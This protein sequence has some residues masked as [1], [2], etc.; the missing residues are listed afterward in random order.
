MS[1]PPG[2]NTMHLKA[3]LNLISFDGC[4]WFWFSHPGHMILNTVDC[5]RPNYGRL[6]HNVDLMMSDFAG[7]AS[8]FPMTFSGGKYT[9]E[10][11]R[12]TAS[13]CIAGQ[14]TEKWIAPL[15]FPG[16]WLQME[17][18]SIVFPLSLSPPQSTSEQIWGYFPRMFSSNAFWGGGKGR[19]SEESRKHNWD[20]L[21][22]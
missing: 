7:G 16:Y 9:G 1:A 14:I 13:K 2:R 20:S 12:Y 18:I 4:I 19:G 21:I 8:G 22:D 3:F 6:P 10:V 11:D 5:T 17:W 15:G